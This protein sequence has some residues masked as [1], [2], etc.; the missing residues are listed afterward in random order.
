MKQA[1]CAKI[2]GP[3]ACTTVFKADTAEG[4]IDQAW[5]HLQ[6]DHPKQ[7]ADIMLNSK[8]ENDKWMANFKTITFPSL[9]DAA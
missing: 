1:T 4:M 5:K 2:G 3:A 8:E 9:P 6:A 7:A